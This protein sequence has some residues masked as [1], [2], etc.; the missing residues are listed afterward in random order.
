MAARAR[1][2]RIVVRQP[3]K[4]RGDLSW[5]VVKLHP[6]RPGQKQGKREIV[7]EP[8]EDRARAEKLA[9][10]MRKRL[11]VQTNER[12]TITDLIGHYIEHARQRDRDP[13][14]SGAYALNAGYLENHIGASEFGQ[15]LP[16]QLE[17]GDLRKCMV[18]VRG[19]LGPDGTT[20]V[21]KLVRAGFRWA[22]DK[23]RI[24]EDAAAPIASLI[25][26]LRGD[27]G[28]GRA[29]P[30][31]R[32]EV[33]D[34][35][36]KA[37]QI[38]PWLYPILRLLFSTGLRRGEV[39][40]LQWGDVDCPRNRLHLARQISPTT[41]RPERLK[42]R[43]KAEHRLIDV[44]PGAMAMLEE[45][46]G[47]ARPGIPWVF[48]TSKGTHHHP[49]N[50]NRAYYA[51]IAAL[52]EEQARLKKTPIQRLKLHATRHTFASL[53]FADYMDPNWVSR[54]LGHHSTAFTLDTY[55]HLLSRSRSL[56]AVEFGVAATS[57]HNEVT[58]SPDGAKK[59]NP[60]L[61]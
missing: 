24:R 18:E 6:R 31:E 43:K 56:S 40:A 26:E 49:S 58:R 46:R 3:Y 14:G 35:L 60:R 19:R 52:Q 53:A 30:Y 29:M 57:G 41:L 33:E 11:V 38:R 39:L 34:L 42:G 44:P 17:D 59:G 16:E 5:H 48:A 10:M 25:G 50:V 61:H 36:R 47:E 15:L 23:G 54:Q 21:L 1:H 12:L 7:P 20:N 51:V 32:H 22:R 27:T 28:R 8:F 9:R 37:E 2:L 45:L 55:V 4:Y 13:L